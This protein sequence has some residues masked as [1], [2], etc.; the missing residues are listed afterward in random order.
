MHAVV[1]CSP[2]PVAHLPCLAGGDDR[3]EGDGRR[4]QEADE[5]RRGQIRWARISSR[6][7]AA[8]RSE[9]N[10]DRALTAK[11]LIAC[12]LPLSGEAYGSCSTAA[13]VAM[14]L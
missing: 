14:A 5:R 10:G 8:A 6:P 3:L 13:R 9:A 4:E 1:R 2:P 11:V 7:L 12:L